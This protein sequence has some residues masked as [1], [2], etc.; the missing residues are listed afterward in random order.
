[1]LNLSTF[2]S[3]LLAAVWLY[4]VVMRAVAFMRWLRRTADTTGS[5]FQKT[6]KFHWGG[7]HHRLDVKFRDAAGIEH[8]LESSFE[9]AKGMWGRWPIGCNV[10][11]GYEP[12]APNNSELA[13]ANLSKICVLANAVQW[14]VIFVFF[15]LFFASA[16]GFRIRFF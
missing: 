9:D 4:H 16:L 14:V 10:K 12:N 8:V 2:F 6:R 13:I 1:M 7:L 11:I 15:P 3:A 5:V